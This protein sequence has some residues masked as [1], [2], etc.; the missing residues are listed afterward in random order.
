MERQ[1]FANE[2]I[3]L[4]DFLVREYDF[5][6]PVMTSGSYW[7]TLTFRNAATEVAV[8]YELGTLPWLVISRLG[9][10]GDEIVPLERVNLSVLSDE[11][12]RSDNVPLSGPMMLEDNVVARSLRS[13]AHELR[14]L[15]DPFL[16]GDFDE[17]PRFVSRQQ[18]IH[19]NRSAHD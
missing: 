17:W 6:L 5:S 14:R 10:R 9:S 15:G 1:A 13:Q 19:R 7:Q 18:E 8:Y 11:S 3:R 16:R 2:V 12:D 4:F